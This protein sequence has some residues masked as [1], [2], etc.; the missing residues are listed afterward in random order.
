MSRFPDSWRDHLPDPRGYYTAAL[1][2]LGRP[3]AWE[4]AAATCLFHEDGARALR[5]RLAGQGSWKCPTCGSGDLVSFHQR[6]R[7][8]GFRDAVVD[9]TGLH[10]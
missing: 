10:G 5:V 1:A 3:D 2:D 7:A 8:L 6:R 9:L 4:W